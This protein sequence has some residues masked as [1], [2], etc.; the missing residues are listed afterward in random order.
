MKVF[1]TLS[2]LALTISQASAAEGVICNGSDCSPVKVEETRGSGL[3]NLRDDQKSKLEGVKQLPQNNNYLFNGKADQT[4]TSEDI[5]LDEISVGTC[6]INPDSGKTF[7]K[8]L[9]KDVAAGKVRYVAEN[10]DHQY[11][12]KGDVVFWRMPES[13]AFKKLRRYPCKRTPNLW[14]SEYV[15][16]CTHPNTVGTL[17]C[18]PKP[19]L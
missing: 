11:M 4:E 1:F 5:K 16:K 17:Y 18:N 7:Y 10:E 14:D 19:K 9:E 6:L 8:V 2:I 12:L 3:L 13:N 15:N